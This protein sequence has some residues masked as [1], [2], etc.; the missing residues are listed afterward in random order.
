MA[1]HFQGYCPQPP[2][3]H[4]Q[5]QTT[6]CQFIIALC[7]TFRTDA[8]R[9]GSIWRKGVSR[10]VTKT[11]SENPPRHQKSATSSHRWSFYALLLYWNCLKQ[12]RKQT[13]V[14]MSSANYVCTHNTHRAAASNACVA[15]GSAPNTSS[16]SEAGNWP[17]VD[18]LTLISDHFSWQYNVI[19]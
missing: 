3:P 4:S 19:M 7:R 8:H 18:E 12:F 14:K 11:T 10:S 9:F 13:A 16:S 1:S 5:L 6:I 15:A 2:P 17:K